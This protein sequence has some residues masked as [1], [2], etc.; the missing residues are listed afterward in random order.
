[1]NSQP[2]YPIFRGGD[3]VDMQFDGKSFSFQ[4]NRPELFRAKITESSET[5]LIAYS[6][7]EVRDTSDGTGWEDDPN[8]RAGTADIC[9]AYEF[10]NAE[11]PEGSIVWM[12]EKCYS[13]DTQS[14]AYEFNY[15]A[16]VSLTKIKKTMVA[17]VQ[18][19]GNQ[20]LVTYEEV[21]I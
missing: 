8:G 3:G 20:L 15:C 18:C 19:S 13:D 5:D 10:N 21:E 11:V 7:V 17:S 9:P 4:S 16:L 12:R 14:I 1:M 6:W 2:D